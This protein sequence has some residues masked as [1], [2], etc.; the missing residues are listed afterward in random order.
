MVD[1]LTMRALNGRANELDFFC[2]CRASSARAIN[3]LGWRP[4][5]PGVVEELASLPKPLDL[6]SVYPEPKR[7]AAAARVS[8]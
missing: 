7:Q 5:R 1:H 6:N 8:F 4:H 3:E 2:N